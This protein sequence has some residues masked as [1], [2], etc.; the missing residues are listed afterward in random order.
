MSSKLTCVFKCKAVSGKIMKFTEENLQQ[1]R[2]K[3]CI[4]IALNM[5][6]SDIVFPDCVDDV[7]EYHSGCQKNFLAIPKKYIKKY[8]ELQNTSTEENA[9]PAL[10]DA[11][12]T[13]FASVSGNLNFYSNCFYYV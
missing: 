8:E 2:E 13:S 12:S 9:N 11:A 5:K 4:R 6:Y 7:H 10:V 1:C 3:L